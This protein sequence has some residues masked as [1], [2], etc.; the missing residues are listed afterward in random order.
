[1]SHQN[2]AG[3]EEVLCA[4]LYVLVQKPSPLLFLLAQSSSVWIEQHKSRRTPAFTPAPPA[5]AL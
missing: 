2:F 4:V 3:I 5:S 1:M